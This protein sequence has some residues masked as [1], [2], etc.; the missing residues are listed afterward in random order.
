MAQLIRLLLRCRTLCL[1]YYLADDVF[2]VTMIDEES[3]Y[4]SLPLLYANEVVIVRIQY[5]EY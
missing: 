3:E 1:D 2:V 4:F 5:S